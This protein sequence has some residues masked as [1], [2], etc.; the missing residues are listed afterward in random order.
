MSESNE[1]KEGSCCKPGS[2]C[3][4]CK[5]FFIGILVGVLLAVIGLCFVCG[6]GSMCGKS[7]MCPIG[8]STVQLPTQS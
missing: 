6:K 4:S 7:K 2:G 8:Q 5:K 1:K 3:C